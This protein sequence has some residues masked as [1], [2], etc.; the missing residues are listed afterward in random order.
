[1]YNSDI[2]GRRYERLEG[3]WHG[4]IDEDRKLSVERVA[5][6][7]ALLNRALE[8]MTQDKLLT[9]RFCELQK[10]LKELREYYT[11]SDW[12]H[13]FALDEQGLLPRDL[14][15]GV[16]SEDGIDLALESGNEWTSEMIEAL[17]SQTYWI[18]DILPKQVPPARGGRYFAAED[19]FLRPPRIGVIRQN[20]AELLMK[21]GCYFNLTV[22][23][24]EGNEWLDDPDPDELIKLVCET[25]K[26]AGLR[27]AFPGE[28]ALFT[29]DGGDT[30]MTVYAPTPEM[31]E[32]IQT[33]APTQGLFVW[34]PEQEF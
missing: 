10:C 6:N 30:Y 12:K 5:R 27:V 13:D 7:E 11:G 9:P 19:Y 20:Q 17:M 8:L 28:G 18:V 23:R 26:A 33:I 22:G 32:L 25:D 4:M 31:L 3:A 24:T 1:M 34:Q 29:L 2:A 14:R 15:R 16:L 21:L